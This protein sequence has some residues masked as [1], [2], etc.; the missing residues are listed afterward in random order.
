MKHV[1]TQEDIDSKAPFV[2]EHSF[3]GEEIEILEAT[4]DVEVGGVE[5][6]DEDIVEEETPSETVQE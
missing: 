4:T 1:I 3:V 6:A 2:N 5:D